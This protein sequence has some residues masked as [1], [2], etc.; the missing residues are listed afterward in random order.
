MTYKEK[1][2]NDA[3]LVIE[4]YEKLFPNI[5]LFGLGKIMH[6]P[7]EY[8][9]GKSPVELCGT[10]DCKLLIEWLQDRLGKEND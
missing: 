5:G 10:D 4:L 1:W 7:K 9:F 3:D 6:T 2:E 8:L